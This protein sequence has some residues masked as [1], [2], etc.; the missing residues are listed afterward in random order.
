MSCTHEI[1]N[2]HVV[3]VVT[4]PNP[5]Q[6]MFCKEEKLVAENERLRMELGRIAARGCETTLG[7]MAE[8]A[9]MTEE[10][11]QAVDAA[12]LRKKCVAK[13]CT[14]MVPITDEVCDEHLAELA[15]ALASESNSE[16][17]KR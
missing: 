16:E 17:P 7:F 15:D 12:R 5:H 9:L 10:Q 11:R 14:I 6:C 2:G 8:R 13:G 4:N 1:K 3:T